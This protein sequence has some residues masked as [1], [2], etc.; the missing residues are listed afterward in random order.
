MALIMGNT[1]KVDKAQGTSVRG[2]SA[3]QWPSV[4]QACYSLMASGGRPRAG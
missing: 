3:D 4:E 2:K 1:P